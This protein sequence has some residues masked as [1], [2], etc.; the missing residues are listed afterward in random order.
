MYDYRDVEGR[1]GSKLEVNA[2][3]S[4]LLCGQPVR[5]VIEGRLTDRVLIWK[6]R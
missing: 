1:R 3:S 5:Q 6:V 2:C 4:G